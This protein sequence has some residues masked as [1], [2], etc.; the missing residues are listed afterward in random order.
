MSK[1]FEYD[2]LTDIVVAQVLHA[3]AHC[4]NTGIELIAMP[5]RAA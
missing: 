5:E 1:F 4:Q 3:E 2:L